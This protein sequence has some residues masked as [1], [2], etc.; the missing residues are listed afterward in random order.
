MQTNVDDGELS[1]KI[2]P[3]IDNEY[4]CGLVIV[5]NTSVKQTRG[6]LIWIRKVI[7]IKR[8]HGGVDTGST[9]H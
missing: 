4:N 9:V 3:Q 2:E 5:V 8:G 7:M 6:H 1:N